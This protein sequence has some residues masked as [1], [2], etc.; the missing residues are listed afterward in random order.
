MEHR[1]PRR[2]KYITVLTV[3][4]AAALLITSCRSGS[5]SAGRK[6]ALAFLGSRRVETAKDGGRLYDITEFAADPE[7][8]LCT[9]GMYDETHVLLLYAHDRPGTGQE[10]KGPGYT[11]CLLD[12]TDGSRQALLSFP[13]AGTPE[14]FSDGTQYLEIINASPLV[15]SDGLNGRIYMPEMT[16]SSLILPEWLRGAS[17]FFDGGRVLLSSERGMIFQI[18]AG[19]ELETLWRLPHTL[20]T[21]RPVVSGHENVLTFSTLLGSDPSAAIL[22]DVDPVSGDSRLY[23]SALSESDFACSDGDLLLNTA[24]DSAPL[25]C[26]CSPAGSWRRELPIPEAL[27]AAPGADTDAAA[28]D[29]GA[30]GSAGFVSLKASPLSLRDGWCCWSLSDSSGRPSALYLWDTASARKAPWDA[31]S[32]TGWQEPSP[33]DYGSLSEFARRLEDR[34]GVRIVLGEN[35]P[36]VFSDY[37]AQVETDPDMIR[38]TLSVLDNVLSRYPEGYFTSLRGNYYRDVVFYLTGELAPLDEDYSIS[39]AGAFTTDCD[40]LCQLA[41]CLG[42]DPDPAMVVHELTHAADYRFSGEDLWDDDEWNA[43]NP[44][45]FSYYNSYIDENGESYEFSGSK[46]YTAEGGAPDDEIYFIDAYSKTYS[47]EDRARLMES[48]LT[49]ADPL[50]NY[51]GC[52]HIQEKLAYYARFLRQNLDDGTW[53]ARTEWEEA[54][55]S[56]SLK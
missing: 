1:F 14:G 45:G 20:R 6:K 18:T 56:A 25:L 2:H 13:F 38:G 46:A 9:Y 15:V 39:N 43:M 19:G 17:V 33:T 49:G 30:A 12:L 23:Q 31:P 27:M 48:L 5:G 41:L 50:I 55:E 21:L 53:P 47:M 29:E 11:A 10:R 37:R 35:I 16:P 3:L 36:A 44:A 24:Y 42:S 54:L 51:G 52:P 26:V 4:A 32:E 34:Y 28:S 22:A 8:T 7:S 40:G